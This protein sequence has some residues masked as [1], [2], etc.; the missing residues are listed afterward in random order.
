MAYTHVNQVSQIRGLTET[1][2][3][4]LYRLADRAD[5]DGNNVY[6]GIDLLAYE[7]RVDVR[8][9]KYVLR[10]LED[11]GLIAPADS[12]RTAPGRRKRYRLTFDQALA[13]GTVERQHERARP[14]GPRKTKLEAMEGLDLGTDSGDRVNG[15]NGHQNGRGR[16]HTPPAP[17][18]VQGIDNQE[19]LEERARLLGMRERAKAF[20]VDP[21]VGNRIAA[22]WWQQNGGEATRRLDEIE[23]LIGG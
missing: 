11:L 23:Q 21:S 6:P 17:P 5:K 15:H 1:E 7:C 2:A 9:V 12:Y 3:F 16:V 14:K 18:D 4:V 22:R 20:A 13:L 19:L 8:T 10:S